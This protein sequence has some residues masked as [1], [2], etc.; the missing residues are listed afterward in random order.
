MNP[1]LQKFRQLSERE[2][3]LVVLV[4]AFMAMLLF[5]LLVWSPLNQSVER[6]RTA[7]E[8]QKELLSW[9]QQN[10]NRI[11]QL[12]QSGGSA[13]RFT[14]SLTQAVNQSANQHDIMITRMQPQNEQLQVWV[15]EADFNKVLNWLEAIESQGIVILDADFS[16]T[17]TPGHIRIRRLQLSKS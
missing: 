9:V 1:I 5:Y 16:E 8:N 12:K 14:G 6:N 7:I 17:S 3:R 15:D 10:A 11:I 13:S 4:A 2:Q